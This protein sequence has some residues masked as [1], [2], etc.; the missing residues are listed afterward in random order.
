MKKTRLFTLI[1]LILLTLKSIGF[2]QAP[3]LGTSA[4]FTFFT[5][6]GNSHIAR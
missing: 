2:S 6:V 3:N 5:A 1:S 4:N